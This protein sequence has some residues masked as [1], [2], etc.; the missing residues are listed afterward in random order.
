MFQD[1]SESAL[2]EDDLLTQA[3]LQ[4]LLKASRTTIWRLRKRA[5]LPHSKVGGQYRY[6]RSDIMRWLK[7]SQNDG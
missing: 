2:T 1:V 5:G 7:S 3:E 6:R 4:H